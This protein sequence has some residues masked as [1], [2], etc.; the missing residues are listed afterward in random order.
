MK[1][2]LISLL[3]FAVHS[4]FAYVE[5]FEGKNHSWKKFAETF[6]GKTEKRLEIIKRF[7]PEN[8]IVFEAGAF[9]GASSV[10]LGKL[11][12]NGKI[13]SFEA[14]PTRFT[15]YQEKARG[16]TNLQGYNLAVNTYNGIATFYLCWGTGGKNP[17]YEGASSLLPAS[18]VQKAHYMGPVI[19][20]PCVIL[21]DW[22]QEHQIEKFDFMWLDLEGFELPFLKSSPNMLKTVK[23]IYTETNFFAF[24]EGHT[25][26]VD[27]RAFL[28]SQGFTMIAHWYLE[29]VQGDA[30][31]VRN[32]LNL[33]QY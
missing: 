2:V 11:W 23:V 32:E 9:D 15:E 8:P 24:R 13:I 12:P 19:T 30:I 16:A 27:L 25:Q 20:V 5:K 6:A 21:D 10:I 3:I 17:I 18:E 31:F 26:Y 14:N 22:C 28:E 7:L 33:S 1:T 29:G 4:V